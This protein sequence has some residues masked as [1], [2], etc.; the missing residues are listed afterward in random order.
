MTRAMSHGAVAGGRD[1]AAGESRDTAGRTARW[2]Q[3]HQ[4]LVQL[5]KTRAGLDF[6]E[7]KRL[8]EALRAR[9]H[10]RLGFGSF[11]EYIEL[12]QGPQPTKTCESWKNRSRSAKAA[13]THENKP[14]R[15]ANAAETGTIARRD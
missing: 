4:A 5:A 15:P 2:Q 9:A 11:V 12:G 8:L 10:E 6:D 13:T 7:G 3:A 1:G 14:A